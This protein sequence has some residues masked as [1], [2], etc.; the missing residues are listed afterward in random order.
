MVHVGKHKDPCARIQGIDLKLRMSI[1]LITPYILI[2]YYLTPI[3]AS[4]TLHIKYN[5]NSSQ[6]KELAFRWSLQHT[7]MNHSGMPAKQ[8]YGRHGLDYPEKMC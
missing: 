8:V 6:M 2:N 1:L 4:R 3:V 7:P 5:T